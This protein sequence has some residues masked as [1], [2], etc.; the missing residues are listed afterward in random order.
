[1]PEKVALL[2]RT[3]A[4]H[5]TRPDSIVDSGS[6]SLLLRTNNK[7]LFGDFTVNL[8]GKLI[9]CYKFNSVTNQIICFPQ[10]EN[11]LLATKIETH[12]TKNLARPLM[13]DFVDHSQITPFAYN[14]K[15]IRVSLWVDFITSGN[16]DEKLFSLGIYVGGSL[17]TW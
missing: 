4:G 16:H 15:I 7:T 9:T 13:R 12:G 2:H 10:L 3:F 8:T 14:D 11:R 5:L 6:Y 1:L 17:L